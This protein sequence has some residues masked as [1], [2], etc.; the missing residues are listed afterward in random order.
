MLRRFVVARALPS[1]AY[2]RLP[3]SPSQTAFSE[4]RGLYIVTITKKPPQWEAWKLVPTHG[5][6]SL[7]LRRFVVARAL[8]SPAYFRLPLSPSQTAFSAVRELYIV[9]V[10]T[11]GL[12]PRTH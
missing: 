5:L 6:T 3:L 7:M 2:F 10:P 11:H 8:P 1:S 12:E 9:M 4:V